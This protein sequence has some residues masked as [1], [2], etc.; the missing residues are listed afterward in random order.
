MTDNKISGLVL[1][2]LLAI[3]GTVAGGVVQGYWDTKLSQMDFQSKLIL[4]AL[5]PEDGKQRV[6]SLRFLVDANLIAAPD[7]RVGLEK[8]LKKGEKGVLWRY[9]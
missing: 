5:E 2:G 8:I 9:Y 7:V 1:T 6:E 4:R 3:F